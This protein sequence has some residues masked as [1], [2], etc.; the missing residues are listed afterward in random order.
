MA[1]NEK[2]AKANEKQPLSPENAYPIFVPYQPEKKVM[3]VCEVCG[4]AN[5]KYTALCEQCSNYL[6]I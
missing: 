3:V 4:H 1:E 6:D 5:P 2:Q